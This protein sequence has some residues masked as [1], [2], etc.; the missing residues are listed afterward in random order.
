[1]TL[2]WHLQ[3]GLIVIPKSNSVE[4]I[5]ENSRVFDFEL[6]AEDLAQI[7]TLETGTRTGSNPDTVA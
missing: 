2:R 4:R 7:A 6:D 5:R 3:N 1:V